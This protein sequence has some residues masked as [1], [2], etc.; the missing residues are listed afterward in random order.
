MDQAKL[1]AKYLELIRR[2]TDRPADMRD[3]P[4]QTSLELDDVECAML[5]NPPPGC[6]KG[7]VLPGEMERPAGVPILASLTLEEANIKVMN[8]KDRPQKP[9]VDFT[10]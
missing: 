1:Q 3:G 6:R 9:A 4:S 2:Y 8:K 5:D 10:V 7:L